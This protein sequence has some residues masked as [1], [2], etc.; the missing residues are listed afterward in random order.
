MGQAK[1][2]SQGRATATGRRKRAVARVR[3]APGTGTI[4]VNGRPAEEYFERETSVM[5]IRQPLE[6]VERAD[7]ID[8][9]ASVD[10][11]GGSGQ[12]GAVRHG[13]ARAL[14][15]VEPELRGELKKAGMLTRDA[16]KKERKKPGQPGARKKF[17]YSK[18]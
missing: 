4:T 9:V 16:R 17:Q 3:I 6:L 12:A 13:V 14:T 5:L 15:A 18:R 10:G 7:K 1:V 8:V 11:G 2:T